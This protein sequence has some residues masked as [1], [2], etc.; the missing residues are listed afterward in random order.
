MPPHN[1]NSEI[2]T[3]VSQEHLIPIDEFDLSRNQ[4]DESEL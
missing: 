1:G 4:T 3:S 2:I